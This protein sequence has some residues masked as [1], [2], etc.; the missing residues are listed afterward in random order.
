MGLLP[1]REPRVEGGVC[2]VGGVFPAMVLVI[3]AYTDVLTS[4]SAYPK[5]MSTFF[6]IPFLFK[7]SPLTRKS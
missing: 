5:Q 6:H 3:P 4:N 2:V 7:A 1:W